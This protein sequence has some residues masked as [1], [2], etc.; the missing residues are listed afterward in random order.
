MN[1]FE[2]QKTLL[3]CLGFCLYNNFYAQKL[4][5]NNLTVYHL[6]QHSINHGSVW[7]HC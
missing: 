5:L 6:E 3:Y 4:R 2:T 1:F 7:H